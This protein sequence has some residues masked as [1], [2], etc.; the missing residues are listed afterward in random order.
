M[1]YLT[2]VRIG[3]EIAWECNRDRSANR[4]VSGTRK[5]SCRTMSKLIEIDSRFFLFTFQKYGRGIAAKGWPLSYGESGVVLHLG[6][7]DES[8]LKNRDCYVC[9]REN[10]MKKEN[11]GGNI[12]V[13]L[14][15]KNGK[16]TGARTIVREEKEFVGDEIVSPLTMSEA[17]K[18]DDDLPALLQNLLVSVEHA[19][20]RVPIENLAFPCPKCH[21]YL[22]LETGSEEAEEGCGCECSARPRQVEKKD[23]SIQTSPMFEIVG[24]IPHIDSDEDGDGREDEEED[25]CCVVGAE[26]TTGPVSTGKSFISTFRHISAVTIRELTGNRVFYKTTSAR[27]RQ[28]KKNLINKIFKS[29]ERK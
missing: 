24:S 11:G 15:W 13:A 9:L 12:E 23:S 28:F 27:L 22:E 18:S 19:I 3:G 20:H 17:A 6:E 14:I 21:E 8:L 4:F 10:P 5:P 7:I 29:I 2:F 1:W 16:K 26:P 25:R